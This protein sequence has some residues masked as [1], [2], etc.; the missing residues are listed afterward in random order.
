MGPRHFQRLCSRC[1]VALRDPRRLWDRPG[2]PGQGHLG[3]LFCHCAVWWK[4][5]TGRYWTLPTDSQMSPLEPAARG[6][7]G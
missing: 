1:W 5:R 3:Q 2:L 4:P 6:R 7:S